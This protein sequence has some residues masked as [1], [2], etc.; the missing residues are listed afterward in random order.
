[1]KRKKKKNTQDL[2]M[3]LFSHEEMTG[4]EMPAPVVE[5][6]DIPE[7]SVEL[8][9]EKRTIVPDTETIAHEVSYEIDGNHTYYRAFPTWNLTTINSSPITIAV[10]IWYFPT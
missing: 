7:P 3:F 4:N 5:Q 10:S 1:M 6:E 2:S 8:Q 9:E